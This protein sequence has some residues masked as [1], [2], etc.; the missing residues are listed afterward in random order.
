MHLRSLSP[1]TD[2]PDP[3]AGSL[4]LMTENDAIHQSNEKLLTRA[5]QVR[6]LDSEVE[7]RSGGAEEW[8]S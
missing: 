8:R 7:L 6:N 1:M 2:G 4:E 5:A 3:L